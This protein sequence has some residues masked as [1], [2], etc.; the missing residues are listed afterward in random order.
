LDHDW[1]HEGDE[2]SQSW[3]GPE[4]QWFCSIYPRIHTFV[5]AP[6]ILEIAPGFGRWTQFL[7][8]YC[9]QLIVVDLTPAC[10]EACKKRF[11]AD[12]HITYHIN[13][14]KSLDML[15]DESL[16]F[17]FSF[18]SLVHAEADIIE[19]YLGQLAKKLKNNGVGFIHHSNIGMF[20]DSQTSRVSFENRQWRAESMTCKLFE[21][22]CD[23]ANLQCINQETINW[24]EHDEDHLTDCISS[25]TLKTSIW[26]RPNRLIV[27]GKFWDEAQYIERL[28]HGYT[29]KSSRKDESL[30]ANSSFL[31][32]LTPQGR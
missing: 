15:P 32:T 6:T 20:V 30:R 23:R 10:I 12:S 4:P 21:E 1:P 8:N 17:A 14:G 3:G 29:F 22:L 16:D 11:Q 31:M 5:P 7:R 9:Q 27:N 19:A 28:S 13:D 2:W 25:F 18:D 26:A 24:G